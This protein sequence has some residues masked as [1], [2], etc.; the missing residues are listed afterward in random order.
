MRRQLPLGIF[1]GECQPAERGF[2]GPGGAKGVPA[3]G[4]GGRARHAIGE[5]GVDRETFHRIVVLGRGAVQVE[6]RDVRGRQAGAGQRLGHGVSRTAAARLGGGNMVRIRTGPGAQQGNAV[7]VRWLAGHQKQH[8][9]FADI[10]AV[11][12]AR[13]RVAAFVRHRFKG[14]EAIDGQ[15]AQAVDAP[16]Q[17]RVAQ[18]HVE[19]PTRTEQGAG[20]GGAGGGNHVGRAAEV[21]PRREEVGRSAELLLAIVV[22]VRKGLIGQVAGDPAARFVDARGAGAQNYADAATTI[23]DDRL[24][25]VRLDLEGGGEQQLVVAAALLAERRRDRRQQAFHAGHGQRALGY[26]AAFRAHA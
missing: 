10:D 20:A 24:L 12:I 4:F 23:A 13:E 5:D 22:A 18:V 8:G 15:L 11:A 19:Q 3:H 17:N 26:P 25:N 7:V 1:R 14:R 6:I 9:R 2:Q 21:Q 16:A